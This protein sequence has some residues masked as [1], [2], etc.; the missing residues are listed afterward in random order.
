[1]CG[2]RVKIVDRTLSRFGPGGRREHS[3]DPENGR[4][5]R[6]ANLG[7]CAAGD[8]PRGRFPAAE[9]TDFR[10]GWVVAFQKEVIQ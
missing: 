4:D 3:P 7:R 5:D 9:R 2:F 1:L 10:G 6:G 8:G